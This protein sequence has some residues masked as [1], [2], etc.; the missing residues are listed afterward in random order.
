VVLV[1]ST[2]AENL[3]VC[4][5]YSRPCIEWE[6]LKVQRK[7]HGDRNDEIYRLR[8]LLSFTFSRSIVQPFWGVQ[9]DGCL[10]GKI[11]I[12][13]KDTVTTIADRITGCQSVGNTIP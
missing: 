1:G 9:V 7:Q 12:V 8:Q 3:A 4:I 13:K 5:D 2:K 6:A 10:S 11:E